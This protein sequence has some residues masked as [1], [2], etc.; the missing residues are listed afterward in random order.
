MRVL[1]VIDLKGGV[2][3]RGR[4]GRREQYRPWLSPL[5]GSA[6][7]LAVARAFVDRFGLNEAYLADLDAIAG[8]APAQ[9]VYDELADA[10]LRLWVDAGLRGAADVPRAHVVVA[11]SETLSGPDALARLVAGHGDRVAFS[12]DLRDGVA[13]AAP[14]WDGGHGDPWSVASA[15]VACGVR[16]V[17]VLDLARVGT[18]LGFEM[19]DLISYLV[20]SSNVE[21]YAGGGVRGV[22]DLARLKSLGARGALVASALH[23]GRL[24]RDDL[25]SL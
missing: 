19:E 14:A 20:A 24:T 2:V 8:A 7:P 9:A 1:P 10:E 25:A 5:C 15:A 4:A 3:V 11:G 13:L 6:E 22:G 17:I 23:D 16:R 21:V 18:G 12:L